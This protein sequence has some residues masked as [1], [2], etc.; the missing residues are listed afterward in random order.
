MFSK[1]NS[2]RP[3]PSFISFRRLVLFFILLISVGFLFFHFSTP[4]SLALSPISG[5]IDVNRSS[6]VVSP[7]VF[8]NLPSPPACLI[9]SSRAFVSRQFSDASFF[10]LDYFLQPE[11]YPTFFSE[12]LPKWTSP[13]T[14]TMG[15]IGYGAFPHYDRLIVLPGE[16]KS[17]RFFFHSSFGVRSFQEGR[18][19]IQYARPADANA[20]II[21]LD[22]NTF[23]GFSVGPTFPIFHPSWVKPVDLNVFRPPSSNETI[24]ITLVTA[25]PLPEYSPPASASALSYGFTDFIGPRLV[26]TLEIRSG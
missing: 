13:N 3:I 1:K 4:P 7:L 14:Q 2:S 21:S 5:C 16:S 22:A 11:F 20:L 6:Y 8:A 12:G 25:S 23:S 10:S 26:Y 24:W 9:S 19:L 15:V 17:I 18:L